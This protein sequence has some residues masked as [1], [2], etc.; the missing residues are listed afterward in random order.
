M[1]T[2]KT[3]ISM[4]EALFRQADRLARRLRMTRSGLFSTALREFLERH[5]AEDLVRAINAAHAD[6]GDDEDRAFLRRASRRLPGRS[7]W[8]G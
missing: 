4:D 7:P 5:A 8:K 3:A 1:S 6:G 2:V